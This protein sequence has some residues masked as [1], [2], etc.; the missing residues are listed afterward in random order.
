MRRAWLPPLLLYALLVLGVGEAGAQEEVATVRLDG[1]A[2]FQIGS[3]QGMGADSRA[4]QIEGRLATLL[5]NPD[6]LPP[7]TSRR[8]GADQVVGIAGLP[9]VRV[10]SA[11]AEANLTTMEALAAQWAAAVDQALQRARDRRSAFGGRY[12][13]ETWAPIENALARLVESLA[14]IVP[15]ALAAFLVVAAFWL[16][17][18]SFRAVLRMIFHR[19][20]DD[21]TVESL[22]KQL[23]YYAILALGLVVAADTL[24][25]SPQTVVTGLGL[26]GLALGFALKDIISNFVSGLLILSLRPFEIGDQ[27]V[28][29]GTEG[30][31]ER[32]ELRATRIRTYDGRVALVPNAEVFTSRLVNNTADPIRRG[33]VAVP[34]GYDADLG[35]ALTVVRT[36]AQSAGGVLANPP[37]GARVSDL[38]ADDLV[39]EATFWTD[40][41]RSDFNDTQSAVRRAL[42]EA[43]RTSGISLPE[44]DVRILS[45]RENAPLHVEQH[46]S[47]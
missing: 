24:G 9:I 1:R 26:T 20:V 19:F 12:L 18:R 39:V 46:R 23:T 5:R 37:A 41:R 36:A 25:F 13:L 11:D 8:E 28:V 7:A 22:V 29:G 44:P 47:L 42:V 6:P 32:I 4:R 35:R 30:T 38:G 21:L 3:G 43:L 27:V 17:A 14:R 2:I 34:L 16:L 10:T 40:S 15:K 33:S 31:V 45:T